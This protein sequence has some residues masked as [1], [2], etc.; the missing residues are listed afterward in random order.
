MEIGRRPASWRALLRALLVSCCSDCAHGKEGDLRSSSSSKQSKPLEVAT[1]QAT[2]ACAAEAMALYI[3]EHPP[4][5]RPEERDVYEFGVY[6]GNGLRAWSQTFRKKGVLF[7]H[8]WGFD[9]FE[10][11]PAVDLHKEDPAIRTGTNP[12]MEAG[13]LNAADALG[14]HS[15]VYSARRPFSAMRLSALLAQ[16]RSTSTRT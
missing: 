12:E 3:K 7:R 16:W 13:G 11:L 1:A 8:L 15:F 5:W 10:G 9:S 14:I 2:R 6:T 4:S